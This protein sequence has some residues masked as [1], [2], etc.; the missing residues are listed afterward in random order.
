[1]CRG[2]KYCSEL[3][4]N[5]VEWNNNAPISKP[6]WFLEQMEIFESAVN[7]FI[8]I[9]RNTCLDKI[10]K[11]KSEEIIN[12]FIEHGQMSGRHRDLILKIIP[13]PTVDINQRD[14]SKSPRKLQDAVFLRDG[15]KCRYC[16]DRLISQNFMRLFIKKINTS[17]FQRGKS[18]LTTHGIIH[19]YW[20]VADHVIPWSKGGLTNLENLVSS[21]ATCNYGKAGYT[22]EQ[23][24][25]E[26]PF[27]RSPIL[28]NWNG[29]IEKITDIKNI[30][31]P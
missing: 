25:I 23:L 1:M 26:N 27:N 12:W 24:G 28:D 15:Y 8:S 9:D 19:L 31:R 3:G 11:I 21:C 30:E 7:D 14:L 17:L 22:I 6:I 13:N 18:N 4:A 29:L 20:P 2:K 5:P 16:G 10:S